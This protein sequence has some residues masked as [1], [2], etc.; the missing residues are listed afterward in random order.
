MVGRREAKEW[1]KAHLKGL[2]SSPSAPFTPDFA[3]DE[4]GIVRN[5]ERVIAAGASGVGVGYLDAWG[6]TIAQR[7]HAMD[8][9][10]EATGDRAMCTF[11]TADHSVAETIDLSLMPKR[12]ARRRSSCGSPMN[13]RRRK[14]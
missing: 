13:G 4:A 2:F 12:S 3:L 14:A 10:A 11:Y 5:V 8:L 1:A 9:I 7:K 6:L